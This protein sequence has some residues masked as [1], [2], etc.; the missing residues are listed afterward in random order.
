VLVK[1]FVLLATRAD[2]A[3]AEAEYEA[4]L[5]LT[6]LERRELRRIRLEQAPMPALDLD[7][8]AGIFVGGSPFN[9]SDSPDTKSDVQRR[10]ESEMSALLDL[11]VRRDFPF[12][13]ACYGIGTLGVHQGAVVDR[14]FGEPVGAIAVTLTE[15]GRADPVFGVLPGSFTAY[16]GHKEACT[17]APANAVLL[18]TGTVCP[19]Q[20]FRVGRNVYATQFHPELELD[21]LVARIRAYRHEGYF[22]PAD[23]DATIASVR[24]AGPVTHASLVL[25]AF[26]ERYR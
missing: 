8:Y 23:L 26:A 24:A 21:D 6:G 9:A 17:T 3:V 11:V 5:R 22:D 18:A 14:R 20:A 25:R 13:G 16:V 4:F 12:F 1:P 7:R 19:V 10:V 15:A 2:D